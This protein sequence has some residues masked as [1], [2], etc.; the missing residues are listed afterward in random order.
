[1]STERELWGV[2][3]GERIIETMGSP[4]IRIARGILRGCPPPDEYPDTERAPMGR[5][6]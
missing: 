3:V 1:M 6:W 4:V 2:V 5:Y